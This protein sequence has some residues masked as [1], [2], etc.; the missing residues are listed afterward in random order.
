MPDT[1][2]DLADQLKSSTDPRL[3]LQLARKI[4]RLV[5]ERDTQ[6]IVDTKPDDKPPIVGK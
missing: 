2:K 5:D 1:I 6:R 4:R 3:S